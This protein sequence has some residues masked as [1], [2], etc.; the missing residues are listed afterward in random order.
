[1]PTFI[2]KVLSVYKY[3]TFKT[4]YN[5]DDDDDGASK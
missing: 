3:D 2:D 4:D 5:D 1:V